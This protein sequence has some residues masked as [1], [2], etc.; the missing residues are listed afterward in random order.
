[1]EH[2]K[3]TKPN[4]GERRSAAWGKR[5]AALALILVADMTFAQEFDRV[6]RAQLSPRITAELNEQLAQAR[7][8][9]GGNKNVKVIVRYK[10]APQ[11][12][13]LARVQSRGGRLAA[14]LDLV[15]GASFYVPVSALAALENDPDVEYV[16]V[17][18]PLKA[19]D[20]YTDAA[21]NVAA[22]WNAGYNGAGIGVAVIDS[23]INDSHADLWDST[24]TYSR[25]VYHQDFTGTSVYSSSGRLM[26]DLY[27]HG[28]H[29]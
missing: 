2:T 28:T 24:E 16:S 6:E 21:M 11:T 9:L 12:E 29:V 13:T 3:K 25:V 5:L 17:D 4:R 7:Q 15:K 22:A 1:M 8:G 26:Y 18:H 20:D 10:Q 27:G 23:G 14:R 19:L